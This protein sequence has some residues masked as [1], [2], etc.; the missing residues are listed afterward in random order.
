MKFTHAIL[1]AQATACLVF[2]G[3]KSPQARIGA[4]AQLTIKITPERVQRGEYLANHVAVCM[5]C[6]S[7]RD[8]SKFAGPMIAGTQGAGGEVFD[9]KMGLPALFMGKI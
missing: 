2:I 9:H 5:D 6:H 8:Y 1:V 4:P 7:R 3:C